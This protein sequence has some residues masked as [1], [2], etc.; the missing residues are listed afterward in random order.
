MKIKIILTDD[1]DKTYEGEIEL[2]TKEHKNTQVK[3]FH[4]ESVLEGPLQKLADLCDVE[5]NE[6]KDIIDYVDDEFILT[7]YVDESDFNRRR[8]KICQYLLTAWMKGKGTEWVN[9]YTLIESL[10]KLGIE[11]RN[12]NRSTNPKD[13]IF[14]TKGRKTAKQYS[15]T[16]SGWKNGLEMIKADVKKLN[17][18]D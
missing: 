11:T 4:D 2:K 12:M 16:I 8:A 14:R 13:G 6:L 9:S 17:S 1:D 5:R 7:G 3:S 10:R 15:L 18:K